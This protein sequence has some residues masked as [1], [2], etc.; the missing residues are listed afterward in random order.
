MDYSWNPFAVSFH[1]TIAMQV[2]HLSHC[3]LH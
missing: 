2:K 3:V 1:C